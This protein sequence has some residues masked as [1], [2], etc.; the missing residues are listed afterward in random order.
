MVIATILAHGALIT[1]IGL[2]LAVWIKR[3]SRA[4][5][6]SVGSFIL[7]TAAW[8]IV[9]GDRRQ[10]RS[11]IWAETLLPSARSWFAAIF[12][13]FFTNRTYGIRRRHALVRH[14]LGRRGL[15]PGD[16]AL[17]ADRPDVRRLLRPNP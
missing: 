9:V 12:V 17:V 15:C 16:G 11:R 1:S 3:Q 14:F 10:R 13:T 7:V 8:P 6:M 5:A 4:I 2:A